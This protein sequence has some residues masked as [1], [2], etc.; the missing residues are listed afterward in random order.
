ME[1]PGLRYVK[2]VIGKHTAMIYQNQSD[3]CLSCQND[4]I[5]YPCTCWK[6]KDRGFAQRQ[7]CTQTGSAQIWLVKT[8][9]APAA[10]Y[11]VFL[12]QMTVSTRNSHVFNPLGDDNDKEDV[13]DF[14]DANAED[15]QDQDLTGMC[16]LPQDLNQYC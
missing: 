6:N 10:L 3:F 5:G 16:V 2:A 8:H 7:A 14:T 11:N 9:C 4:C 13:N 1:F 15:S 12:P